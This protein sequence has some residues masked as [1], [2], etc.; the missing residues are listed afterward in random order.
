MNIIEIKAFETNYI[1]L[2]HNNY[3]ECVVVDPGDAKKV[4][5]VLKRSR[6]SLKAI[7][8]THNHYDHINGVHTLN[9]YFPTIKIYGPI[10]TKNQGANIIV[11]EGDNFILLNKNVTV[12]NLPG[13]TTDHIGYYCDSKLFCGDTVFS[14]GCGNVQ[15]G[16]IKKMYESF[17]K[18]KQFPHNTLIYSGHEYTVSNVNFVISILPNNQ[19]IINYQNQVLK[20]RKTKKPTIPTTLQLEL[21]INPF[22][23]CDCIDIKKALNFFP[24]PEEE[25]K[26]FHKLRKK[27]D[28][29][30]KM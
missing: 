21:K 26:I 6:F 30:N 19:N 8:L 2:M 24:N 23:R 28:E 27:K 11:S 29:F 16:L 17:L 20:L 15:Q 4:L 22:L 7:L 1:W 18:I 13:H 5:Q 10:E 9:Q 3:N 25:W 14:A 12:L